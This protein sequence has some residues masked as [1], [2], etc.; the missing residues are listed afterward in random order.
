MKFTETAVD[1]CWIIDLTPFGDE[2]GGFA[3]TFCVD[4]MAAHGIETNVAQANM[5]W[6]AKKGTLR[7]MHRQI[8]PASE[9]KL[10]RCTRGTIV[11]CCLDLRE[12]SPTFGQYAM[13]EL[14][15]DN[16]RALWIPPYCGHGYLTMTDDT[17]I[18]YQVSGMYTP[19]AE[20]GQRYDD[21]AF[22]LEWPGEVVVIS[23]K[24]KSWPDWD[25]KK[26]R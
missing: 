26:I 17:E 24:D 25:G 18:T 4:E 20:R 13:V 14:S 3:R 8:A 2:R 11:D 21:P 1:G 10:V 22:R 19:E 16:R 7:G 5:S 23:D 9:G 15:A 6:N 12:D